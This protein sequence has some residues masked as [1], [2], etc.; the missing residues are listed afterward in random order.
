M[1]GNMVNLRF[2]S[3]L[4]LLSLTNAYSTGV[5]RREYRDFRI[6]PRMDRAYKKIA[7]ENYGEAEALLLQVIDIDSARTDAYEVLIN[8]YLKTGEY[9]RAKPYLKKV[10][11]SSYAAQNYYY[12]MAP[13]MAGAVKLEEIPP[14]FSLETAYMKLQHSYLLIDRGYYKK[15]EAILLDLNENYSQYEQPDEALALLYMTTKDTAKVIYYLSQLPIDNATRKFYE[16]QVEKYHGSHEQKKSI[17]SSET[18]RKQSHYD[19]MNLVYEFIENGDYRKAESLLLDM[20]SE[21]PGNIQIQEALLVVYTERGMPESAE[22]YAALLPRSSNTRNQYYHNAAA[23][24]VQRENFEQVYIYIDS[25]ESGSINDSERAYVARSQGYFYQKKGDI[26]DAESAFRRALSHDESDTDSRRA[27]VG[28]L[29]DQKRFDEA[30]VIAQKLPESDPLHLSLAVGE[31]S[32][33][34]QAGLSDSA[35]KVLSGVITKS[36]VYYAEKGYCQKNLNMYDSAI[37]SFETARRSNSENFGYTREIAQSKQLVADKAGAMAEYKRAIDESSDFARNRELTEDEAKVDLFQLQRTNHYL[38]KGWDFNFTTLVRLDAFDTPFMAVS[39]LEYASYTGFISFEALFSPSP[40]KRHLSV[41]S[42]LLTSLEDQSFVFEESG[43]IALGIKVVPVLKVPVVLVFQ[44]GFGLG[45]YARNFWMARAAGSF[46][47][48]GDWEP[49]KTSRFFTNNYAEAAYLLG[50]NALYLSYSGEAGPQF[51][52]N[53]TRLAGSMTPYAT[54]GFTLNTD[55]AQK[56]VVYR[57]D[58]GVGIAFSAWGAYNRYRSYRMKNRVSFEWRG[59]FV[60][61]SDDWG[62]VRLKWEMNL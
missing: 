39:P 24:E 43:Q 21:N 44:H 27:L 40:L 22:K 61:N 53:S 49:V 17:N 12:A 37:I 7:T 15:A 41:F 2:I 13:K 25:I 34:R 18:V 48:G 42:S 3:L 16:L 59:A 58:G 1:R 32:E 23:R 4:L 50:E 28:I 56:E 31:A 51:T 5:L 30:A 33:L 14:P 11:S 52:L 55:N 62:T 57:F 54:T 35:L 60:T 29:A 9:Y 47:R 45:D 26:S 19:K 8:L 20:E 10:P 6:Y 38:Q 36:E 46:T